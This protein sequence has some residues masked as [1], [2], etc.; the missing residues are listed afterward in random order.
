MQQLV[1]AI[2]LC[3]LILPM[4]DADYGVALPFMLAADVYLV[5]SI[6]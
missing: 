3:H 4:L 5:K 1:Y 2:S 6:R